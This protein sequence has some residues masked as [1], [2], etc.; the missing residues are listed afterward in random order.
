MLDK[1]EVKDHTVNGTF[2]RGLFIEGAVLS[3]DGRIRLLDPCGINL[4]SINILYEHKS[5][6]EVILLLI[7]DNALISV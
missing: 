4:V 5:D 2:I 6:D 1:T 7:Q 3:Q